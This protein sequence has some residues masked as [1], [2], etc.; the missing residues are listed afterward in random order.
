[1]LGRAGNG[2]GARAFRTF[3]ILRTHLCPPYGA[4]VV[5]PKATVGLV[6][7]VLEIRSFLLVCETPPKFVLLYD[8]FC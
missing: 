6:S 8:S 7:N 2:S 5:S 1:M 4:A 3:Y